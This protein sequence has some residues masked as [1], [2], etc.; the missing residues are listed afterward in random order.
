MPIFIPQID[1]SCD[2]KKII[3][4]KIISEEKNLFSYFTFNDKRA[5]FLDKVEKSNIKEWQNSNNNK[6]SIDSFSDFYKHNFKN[7]KISKENAKRF[8]ITK[9]NTYLKLNIELSISETQL[10]EI[11]KKNQ[12]DISEMYLNDRLKIINTYKQYLIF[13]K[14]YWI[15]DSNL[16]KIKNELDK[17]YTENYFKTKSLIIINGLHLINIP[18]LK[19]EQLI[20]KIVIKNIKYNT[21]NLYLNTIIKFKIVHDK[22]GGDTFVARYRVIEIEKNNISLPEN[23][24]LSA[25]CY[26]LKVGRDFFKR[27]L[28][29]S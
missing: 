20:Q 17:K 14:K 9:I 22:Y 1:V 18:D 27:H 21:K 12:K 26:T 23:I 28:Q 15:N 13:T 3:N 11:L 10:D 19:E 25:N 8:L 6:L 24:I 5:S 2:N 16:D 29:N 4:H 7:N